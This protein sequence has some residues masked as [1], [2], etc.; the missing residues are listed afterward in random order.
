MWN[1]CQDRKADQWKIL[2]SPQIDSHMYTQV[3]FYRDAKA[4]MAQLVKNLTA[5]RETWVQSLSCEDPLEKGMAT[6]SSILAWR[7]PQ[8]AKSRTRLSY[9]HFQRHLSGEKI[10]FLINYA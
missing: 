4:L 2:Q 5:M 10:I 1:Q 6:H 8:T 3:I 9:F 7:I